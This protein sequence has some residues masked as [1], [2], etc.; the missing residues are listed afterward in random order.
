MGLPGLV[1]KSKSLQLLSKK[2]IADLFESLIGAVYLDGGL[3]NARKFVLDFVKKTA[4][5]QMS[6]VDYKTELQEI[7]QKN[8]DEHL[9][10]VL[11]G[12]SGPDHD[13]RF[14]VAVYINNNP[15]AYGEGHSK[16]TA[17]QAAAKAAL[18]LMGHK[19]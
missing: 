6:F 10:Y 15:I 18:A 17:E 13:K 1:N 14:N 16:K 5:Q 11:V 7:I 12:E 4:S 3:D 2:N 19:E 9:S 8:P